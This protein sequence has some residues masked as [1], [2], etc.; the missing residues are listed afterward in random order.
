MSLC[1]LVKVSHKASHLGKA[2]VLVPKST[3][4]PNPKVKECP[5]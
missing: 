5:C 2:K 3:N 1:V 4:N